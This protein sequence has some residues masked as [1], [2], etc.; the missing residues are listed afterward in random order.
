M[1]SLGPSGV[2]TVTSTVPAPAGDSAVIEV[3]DLTSK[4][5]ASVSPNL[6]DVAPFRWPR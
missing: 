2:V 1:V 4:L 5:L 3:A 6:T